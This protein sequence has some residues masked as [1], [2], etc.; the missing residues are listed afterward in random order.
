MAD[1]G[2]RILV[3]EDEYLIAI[4]LQDL[5]AEFGYDDVHIAGNLDRGYE[6]L[7]TLAPDF[8]ILDVN[9][10]ERL[11][12]PLATEI[13]GRD[14]PLIFS[15][16]RSADEFPSEWRDHTVIPKPLEPERLRRALK[17]WESCGGRGG[18]PG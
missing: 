1:D 10:G 2:V 6:L 15:T 3:V 13:A 12:F 18:L 7:R 14:I 4:Y 11:V 8:A 9:I 17:E 5:L 16:A